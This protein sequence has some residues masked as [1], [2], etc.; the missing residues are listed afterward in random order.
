VLKQQGVYNFEDDQF[1]PLQ[2][3]FIINIIHSIEICVTLA[4]SIVSSFGFFPAFID[5]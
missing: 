4:A 3:N 1:D 2:S 5:S